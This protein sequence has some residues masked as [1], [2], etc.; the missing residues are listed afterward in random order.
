MFRLFNKLEI[1]SLGA[2]IDLQNELDLRPIWFQIVEIRNQQNLLY[3]F[4]FY[5][6]IITP[7]NWIRMF[8]LCP[9]HTKQ[10]ALYFWS[11]FTQRVH[12]PFS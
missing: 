4:M 10:T 5:F 12:N 7:I 8:I 6:P 9:L 3:Y 2:K 11:K 1:I